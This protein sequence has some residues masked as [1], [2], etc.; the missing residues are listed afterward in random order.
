MA[1]EITRGK[2][3]K[4][5]KV[6]IYGVEG[7]GKT[8][9]AAQFPDPLF[10]DCEGGTDNF[11]VARFQRPTSWEMLLQEVEQVKQNPSMCSTLVIDTIDW[12]EAEAIRYVC[13]SHQVKNIEDFGWSKGYTYLNEE[14]GNLLNLLTEVRDAGINVVLTAHMNI[15]TISLPD[16][17]GAYDRYE[18]KL[19]TA[20]NGNNSQLVK[21]WADMVLFLNY[22]QYVVKDE[23]T[24]QS[25]V[26][27]GRERVMYTNHTAAYDA[28]NRF[29][30]PDQLPLSFEPIA[31]LFAGASEK[32]A[33]D[34]FGAQNVEVKDAPEQPAKAPEAP[35][36]PSIDSMWV[37]TPYSAEEQAEMQKY[38]PKLVDLMK[39][40]D[41][42][43][44]EIEWVA[45]DRK[46][47]MPKGQPLSEY[48]SDF[49][50]QWIIPFWENIMQMIK[51][52]RDSTL[53]F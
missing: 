43:A 36:P 50:Q 14:M 24:K 23:K 25:K 27:G 12:A 17:S 4:A 1:F 30:L 21:E 16:D 22:K 15:R 39:A 45:S 49:I 6:L 3:T 28:K 11:D 18:L 53:P 38:D 42:H 13:D 10:I 46:G 32:K 35:M 26:T 34:L 29:G 9:L 48:P 33:K 37:P 52:R 5:L 19:K 51:D 20:K 2:Q 40:N 8:T 47:Y 41:V 44:N 31:H 7:V